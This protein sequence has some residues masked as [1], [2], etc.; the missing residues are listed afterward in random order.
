MNYTVTTNPDVGSGSGNN[1]LGGTYSVPISGLEGTEEYTWHIQVNDGVNDVDVSSSFT[2]EAVAPAVSNP[3]PE[4]DARYVPFDLSQLSFHLSDPQGDL[5]DYTVETSPDIGSDSVSGVGEGTY[6]IDVSSLDNLTDYTWYVNVTDGVNWKHK[7]FIFQTEPKMV[8]NPFDEGWQYRKNITIDHTKIAGDLKNF[9]V[10]VSTV[11]TDLRDKAQDDGDDILFMDGDGV[12]TRLYHEIEYFDDSSGEIVAWVNVTNLASNQDTILYLYYG[13]SS[14]K[15]QQFPDGVW[16]SNYVMVQHLEETS[17]GTRYDSTSNDNDGTPI[18]YE[19]NEAVTGK[20]DGADDFDGID[21]NI[22]LGVNT[23]N[24]YTG[25]TVSVWIK[26][27]TLSPHQPIFAG[28][29]T[30]VHDDYFTFGEYDYGKLVGFVKSG[31]IVRWKL[32]TDNIV[33]SNGDWYF[34]TLVQDG[35]TPKIY[36]N[37][38]EV[39]ASFE[40]EQD[41]TQW[42][43]DL[44]GTINWWIGHRHTATHYY[45]CNGI[46][47]EVRVSKIVRSFEWI[48]TEYNNQNDPSGFLS[49]GPEEPGP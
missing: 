10:L 6:S 28:S 11:D 5:M 44:Q 19:G 30:A 14:C 8:F 15:S 3:I 34:V 47:D 41:K 13:N 20:I 26:L 31:D 45:Y 36:V 25:G 29:K 32:V 39:S 27:D 43:D 21:D 46:I 40:D 24:S 9:P 12:A 7:M 35:I 42:F 16:D 2:T 23:F 17:T 37:D 38:Y 22:G 4:D 18:N 1:I 33:L 48:K 49:F